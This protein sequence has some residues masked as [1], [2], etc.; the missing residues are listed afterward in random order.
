MVKAAGK[1]TVYTSA[2]LTKRGV[3]IGKRQLYKIFQNLLYTGYITTNMLTGQMIDGKHEALAS[4]R[5]IS[6]SEQHL[7]KG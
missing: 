1:H 6:G 3:K 2:Y 5:S 7:G 4:P